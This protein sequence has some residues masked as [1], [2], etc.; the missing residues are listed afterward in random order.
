LETGKILRAFTAKDGVEVILRTPE[1]SDLDDLLAFINALVDENLSVLPEL[2]KKTRSE[3][4][5]WLNKR[6][7]DIENDNVIGVVAEVDGKV[8]ANSEVVVEGRSRTHVGEIGISV[9]SGYRNIGIG[10]EM[11]KTLIAESRSLGL[12]VLMCPVF[13]T[14]QRARHVYETVGFKET[15]RVPLRIYRKGQYIDDVIMTLVL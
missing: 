1:P 13:A 5:D 14:N 15:G 8:I 4:V 7:T 2:S 12:K 3:E 10:T 9:G 11:M 6:L